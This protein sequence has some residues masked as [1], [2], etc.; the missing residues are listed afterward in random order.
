MFLTFGVVLLFTMLKEAYEDYRRY[1]SDQELNCRETEIYTD[2]GGVFHRVRWQDVKAGQ[3][4]KVGKDQEV[5]ADML[6]IQ[7]SHDNSKDTVSISTMNLDG[8]TNLKERK[9]PFMINELSDFHGYLECDIPNSDLEAWNGNVHSPT[10][11]H[12][13]DGKDVINCNIQNV[14]LR[15]CTLRNVDFV[16]GVVIYLGTDTKIF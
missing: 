1:R 11:F 5:P 10:G 2:G 9:R 8:E 3:I 12:R 6:L 7:V 16:L 13:S 14:L 4:I 15:G